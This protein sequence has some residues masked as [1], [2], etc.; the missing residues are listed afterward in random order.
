MKRRGGGEKNFLNDNEE[1][2]RN[3]FRV[4]CQGIVTVCCTLILAF[5][6]KTITRDTLTLCSRN[7]TTI[8]DLL[9]ILRAGLLKQLFVIIFLKID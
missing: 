8:L 1:N 7:S 3:G 9:S 5:R 4:S 2:L 6:R